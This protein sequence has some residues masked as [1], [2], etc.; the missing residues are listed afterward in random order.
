VS[1]N[2]KE[3]FM[4]KLSDTE[5]LSLFYELQD[6]VE[7][8]TDTRVC[9]ECYEEKPLKEFEFSMGSHQGVRGNCKKCRNRSRSIREAY[10]KK[11]GQPDK[12]YKCPICDRKK[13]EWVSASRAGQS[14]AVDHCHK[15]EVVRGYLCHNCNAGLGLLKDDINN[16]EKGIQWLRRN[17]GEEANEKD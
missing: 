8:Y 1:R 3:I 11:N 4:R 9:I 12:N 16:L 17:E 7:I 10:R 5:Q 2:K 6:E 15:T 13:E 14:W